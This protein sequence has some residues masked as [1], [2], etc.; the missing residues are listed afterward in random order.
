MKWQPSLDIRLV[1]PCAFQY[2]SLAP[3]AISSHRLPGPVGVQVGVGTSDDAILITLLLHVAIGLAVGGS[4]SWVRVLERSG[5]GLEEQSGI[6]DEYQ[7]S[8]LV[9]KLT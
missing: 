2:Y 6:W 7:F 8:K 1:W 9:V 3:D 5:S 4:A